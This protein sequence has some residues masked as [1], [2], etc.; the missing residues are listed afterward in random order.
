M[1]KIPDSRNVNKIASFL[2]C[3]RLTTVNVSHV[4]R[5]SLEFYATAEVYFG[6]TLTFLEERH[7]F[8]VVN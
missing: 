1:E 3:G 2:K 4:Q 7:Y 8:E 6:Y 5:K